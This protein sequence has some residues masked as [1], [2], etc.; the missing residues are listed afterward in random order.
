M[1]AVIDRFQPKADNQLN[2]LKGCFW[3]Q[4]GRLRSQRHRCLAMHGVKNGAASTSG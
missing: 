1:A 3:P 2:R 4:S